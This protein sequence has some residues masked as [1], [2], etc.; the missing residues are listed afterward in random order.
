LLLAAVDM[1]QKAAA[2]GAEAPCSSRPKSPAHG[3]TAANPP[4]AAAVGEWNRQTDGH[5]TVT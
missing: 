2:L 5:R 4:R 3:A 1:D